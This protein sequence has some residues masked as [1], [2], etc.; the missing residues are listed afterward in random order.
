MSKPVF[1]ALGALALSACASAAADAKQNSAQA[2]IVERDVKII[3]MNAGEPCSADA[4]TCRAIEE[5]LAEADAALERAKVARVHADE[6]RRHAFEHRRVLLRDGGFPMAF[7]GPPG[8]GGPSVLTRCER[9]AESVNAEGDKTYTQ[10]CTEEKIPAG[11]VVMLRREFAPPAPPAAPPGV[12]A[13][14]PVPPAAP[15]APPSPQ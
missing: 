9:G 1:M 11:E 15:P 8:A 14:A 10:T 12:A 3:R 4:E 2:P 13:P 6:A 5:A 7:A